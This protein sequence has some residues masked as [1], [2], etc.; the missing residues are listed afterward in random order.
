[1]VQVIYNENHWSTKIYKLDNANTAT[2]GAIDISIPRASNG[3]YIHNIAI[4]PD[5]GDEL[6]SNFFKL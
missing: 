2:S 1:M 4:N 3:A 5:N 6:I